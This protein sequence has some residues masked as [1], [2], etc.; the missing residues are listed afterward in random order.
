MADITL[1]GMTWNHARGYDPMVATSRVFGQRHPGVTITWHKR[2]LQAFADRPIA[3]M[4]GEY[5]LMVIDHP[6]VGEAA[7]S[8]M[9]LALDGQG[10]DAELA[11]M[12]A[13]SVGDSHSSYRMDG[14]QWALAIDA[15]T[16][17]AAWRPDLLE[18]APRRWSQVL[19]LARVNK[20]AFALVPINALMTFMGMARNLNMPLAG[21]EFIAPEHGRQVLEL[22]REIVAL[23]DPCCLEHDPIGIFDW[24]GNTADAP[25]YSPFGYGYTNYSRDGYCAHPLNF[26]DAPGIEREDPSGTV[27]GGTGIAI[28]SACPHPRLAL[29]YAFWIAGASC[30]TGLFF[31]HGG[32]PAHAAAWQSDR[33]N[34]LTRNFFFNTRR[35]MDTSWVRPRY[36]GYMG[37]QARAGDLVHA[38]LA[39]QQG[40]KKTLQLLEHVY[41]ESRK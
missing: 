31:D 16:P 40:I 23:M 8:G 17:V 25:A 32:Q 21:Q 7:R 19:E 28:S 29:D 39:G 20:V 41:Q 14:H 26:C 38:C 12:S 1:Q 27:L 37:F 2:S 22:L 5:D 13:H 10:R 11:D 9:L 36:A 33:C 4:A 35:T 34:A 6:H 3:D 24:M 18:E 15:A 30:Q